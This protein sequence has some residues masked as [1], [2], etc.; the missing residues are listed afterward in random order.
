MPWSNELRHTASNANERYEIWR[1]DDEYYSYE[2]DQDG[3]TM[4]SCGTVA[5]NGL[6][7]QTKIALPVPI[8]AQ[9]LSNFSLYVTLLSGFIVYGRGNENEIVNVENDDLMI[10]QGAAVSYPFFALSHNR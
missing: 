10:S 2:N 6:Y 3:W 5:G 4:V 9:A 7:N 8:Y 1:R